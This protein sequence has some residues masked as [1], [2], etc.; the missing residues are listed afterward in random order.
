MS[1]CNTFM[2][3]SVINKIL[4]NLWRVGVFRK[5]SAEERKN[6]RSNNLYCFISTKIII[7]KNKPKRKILINNAMHMIKTVI[8]RF[9]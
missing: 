4:K 9:N 1:S 6:E 5:S 8:T 7:Y 2:C 3:L